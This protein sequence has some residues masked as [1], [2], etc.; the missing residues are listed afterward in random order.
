VTTHGR[1][2]HWRYGTFGP[3]AEKPYRRRTSDWVR[4]AVAVVLF[5]V[6]IVHE[7]NPGDFERNL[8]ELL[9]GLPDGLRSFFRMLYSLAAIWAVA[10]IVCSALVARRWR[11]A[12][13]LAVAG[14][15]AWFL[16]RLLG[17]LVVVDA[18]L[19]K[20]LDVAT[21]VGDSSPSW[22]VVR[23]AIIVAVIATA[24]PYLTR[25]IRRLGQLLILLMA[26]AAMY[27]GLGLPDGVFA[28]V[29]LGWG[30]SA[31]VHLV[32]GSPGGHPTRAQ[33]AAALAELDVPA[34]DVELAPIQQAGATRMLARDAEGPLRIRVLGRDEAD[35]QLLAKFW[36][37][38]LYKDSGPQLHLTRL[39]DVE[40]EAYTL[41]LAARSGTRVPAVVAAG[42]A[43]P[44]AALLVERPLVGPRLDAVDPMT[45]TDA[46]LDALWQQVIHLHDA[47]VTHSRLNASHIVWTP[48]GPGIADFAD[49]SAAAGR[50]REHADVA[51]LLYSTAGIVGDERAIAS[52]RRVLGGDGLAA[53]LP[54]LQPAAMPAE[55]VGHGRHERKDAKQRVGALR[56]AA[57]TGAGVE[58]PP[59]EELHRVNGTQLLMAVG[60]LIAVFALLS[61]I[62]DP[63]EFW[64][65]IKD[66]DWAWL[67]AALVVS[68]FTNFATAISLMGT[69]PIPLPLMRTAELQLSMSFSNL[70]VPAVGGMAAQIR[71]LQKQ[72]LDLA[73]AVASGGLLAN[74]GNIVAQLML[75]VVA[76]LLAPT[77][78]DTGKI[79][80]DSLA[81][82][83][84]LIVLVV[85]VATGLIFGIPRF[86]R[87]VMP[88]VTSALTTMWA[89]LRSPRR[90]AE[91]LGANMINALMYAAVLDM[92]ILA[93]GGEIN[94][95]TLLAY[96]IFIGTIAS[97][98]PV[99][100][101]GTAVSSVGMSGA[102]VAAG[103]PTEIAVA[104]VLA[105]Q[106]V[107]NFIPAVPGWFATNNLMRDD[108]L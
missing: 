30:L 1:L 23:L 21:R 19:S 71:F 85:A 87:K 45:V 69:V 107:A 34:D 48:D 20:S 18:G 38:L 65:T 36:R 80:T 84:L 99:P 92:C 70:A 67:A 101:G 100:G 46:G 83:I 98:V 47:M 94:F 32:F 5:A 60:T 78:I 88:P 43:G 90:V 41:L 52:A 79:N 7:G 95:W 104:A 76:I 27:L 16:A 91:L 74:V 106:L 75:F 56:A 29:V 54:Y 77:K 44:G 28:A 93:F 42:T 68:F 105:N 35:S 10:I 17:Y 57:A 89:A 58:E 4:L 24:S 6:L 13:D 22:P 82:T 97:L 108:Y 14:V 96:N 51:Q 59:L 37:G 8:F 49:A 50:E 40:H 103:V 72:G 53:C 15:L 86:R 39:E 26:L 12:R 62:G 25:P 63:E 9:N 66:A 61:Q 3:A 55:T 31:I 11:L 33:V 2:E 81:S 73:S 64:N 102:L